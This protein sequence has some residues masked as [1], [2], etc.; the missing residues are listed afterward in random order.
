MFAS[1]EVLSLDELY[2]AQNEINQLK[3]MLERE[4]LFGE[5][6]VPKQEVDNR[7]RIHNFLYYQLSLT[8]PLIKIYDFIGRPVWQPAPALTDRQV[9]HEVDRLL[10]LLAQKGIEILISDPHQNADDRKVYQFITEVVFPKEIKDVRLPGVCYSIDYNY[11]EPDD[12]H[13]CIF[14]ADELLLGLAEP[15]YGRLGSCLA[16]HFYINDNVEDELYHSVVEKLD[17]YKAYTKGYHVV[18]WT[19]ETIDLDAHLRRGVVHLVL[20]YGRAGHKKPLF[21][22][23]GQLVCYGNESNWWNIHRIDLPGLLLE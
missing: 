5:G 21:T 20:H 11:Y 13:A 15:D 22:S 8:A 10:L 4:A 6:K 19:I 16:S 3:Q 7:E 12:A 23:R 17:A 14:I 1:E 2:K 9:M 18:D